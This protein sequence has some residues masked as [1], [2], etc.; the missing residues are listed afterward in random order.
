[1]KK[2][3]FI[4]SLY[5]VL[6]FNNVLAATADDDIDAQRL[7]GIISRATNHIFWGIVLASAVFIIMAA[8]QFLFSEGDPEKVGNAKKNLLFC[9]I[10]IVLALFS[11][12]ASTIIANM[13]GI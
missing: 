8:Y 1:M 4:I 9:L 3:L 13:L 2:Y 6:F 11:K 12:I 5:F 10:A 7:L